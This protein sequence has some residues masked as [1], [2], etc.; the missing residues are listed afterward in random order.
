MRLLDWQW[1]PRF[2]LVPWWHWYKNDY[3]GRYFWTELWCGWGFWQFRSMSK[4]S[5]RA[6]EV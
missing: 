3:L 1:Y 6:A 2:Y 5:E 4:T